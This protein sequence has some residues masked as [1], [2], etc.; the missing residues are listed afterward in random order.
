MAG[1][2]SKSR[3]KILALFKGKDT[4]NWMTNLGYLDKNA[5]EKREDNTTEQSQV[6]EMSLY[7]RSLIEYLLWAISCRYKDR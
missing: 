2:S 4:L 7:F 5:P 3:N 6:D 1:K